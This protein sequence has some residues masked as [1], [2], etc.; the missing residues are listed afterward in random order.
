M[1]RYFTIMSGLRGCY[2]PDNA[3]SIKVD[4][5]RELRS[6]IDEEACNQSCDGQFVG[7]SQKMVSWATAHCWRKGSKGAILPFGRRG[8]DSKPFSIEISPISR[9]EYLENVENE[10]A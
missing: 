3:Y 10:L 1:A 6:Y 4:S 2:M 9:R 8:E 7:L 5:R